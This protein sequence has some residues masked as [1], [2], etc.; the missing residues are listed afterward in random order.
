VLVKECIDEKKRGEK[1]KKERKGNS[2]DEI[3]IV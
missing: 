1:K 3:N 2:H